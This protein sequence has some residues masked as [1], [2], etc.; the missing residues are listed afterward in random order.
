MH[1]TNKS[2]EHMKNEKKTFENRG[3]PIVVFKRGDGVY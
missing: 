1:D 3:V 2:T